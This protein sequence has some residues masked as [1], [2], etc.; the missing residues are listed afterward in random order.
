MEIFKRKHNVRVINLD[1]ELLH[2][3]K[4]TI[5]PRE[6]EY[7]VFGEPEAY[8]LITRV[9]YMVNSEPKNINIIVEP[10]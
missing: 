9:I 5:P 4:T 1:W 10:K 2:E 3:F 8:H 7:I 6:G